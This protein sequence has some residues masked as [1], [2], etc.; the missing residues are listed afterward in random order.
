MMTVHHNAWSVLENMSFSSCGYL[1]DVPSVQPESLEIPTKL[2]TWTINNRSGQ[3]CVYM[4]LM[5]LIR[6]ITKWKV[7]RCL[8]YLYLEN[9]FLNLFKISNN[10]G[11]HEILPPLSLNRTVYVLRK[12]AV[13]INSL[14]LR[15]RCQEVFV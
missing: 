7:V 6:Y 2:L 1:G 8:I 5:H 4:P 13:K 14:F 15:W 9:V 12:F 10:K 11:D 3:T